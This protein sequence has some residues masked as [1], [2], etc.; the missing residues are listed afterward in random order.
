MTLAPK[1]PSDFKETMPLVD[2][3]RSA[4]T[5]SGRQC[6]MTYGTIW[7]LKLFVCSWDCLAQVGKS[8]RPC[9]GGSGGGGGGGGGGGWVVR[10]PLPL[11]PG[12]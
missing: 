1:E 10:T 12:I 8:M 5:M 9:S 2:V 4:T 6:V 7:M 11:S 3:W